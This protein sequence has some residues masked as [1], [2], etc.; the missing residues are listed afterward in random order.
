MHLLKQETGMGGGKMEGNNNERPK[1]VQSSSF[2]HGL[3]MVVEKGER[4][5]FE[6]RWE[7]EV[8]RRT[9]IL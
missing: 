1:P 2:H 7:G 8:R 4:G 5:A 6:C 3:G 9:D